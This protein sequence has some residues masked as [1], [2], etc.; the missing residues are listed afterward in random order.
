MGTFAGFD[1]DA[2]QFWHE[3]A[4]EMSREWFQANKAR[5]EALW[6]APMQAASIPIT[7]ARPT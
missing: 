3:L 7:R 2:M 5:Y 6:V 1:R 4:A